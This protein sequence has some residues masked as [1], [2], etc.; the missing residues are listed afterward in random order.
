MAGRID[1]REARS[2]ARIRLR[3]EDSADEISQVVPFDGHDDSSLTVDSSVFTG[4]SYDGESV[5]KS[6]AIVI[7]WRHN[8]PAQRVDISITAVLPDSRIGY[9]YTAPI[10]QDDSIVG[11]GPDCV[12]PGT[13][14]PPHFG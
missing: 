13:Q 8:L 7:G 10:D 9:P 12:V 4:F 6:V 3:N 14:F 1:Q 2:I 5:M 11:L